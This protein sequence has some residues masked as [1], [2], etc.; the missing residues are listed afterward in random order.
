MT[1]D[2]VPS[3]RSIKPVVTI[4]SIHDNHNDFAYWKSQPYL[5]RLEAL[6]E[7]RAE[8]H[9]WRYGYEPGFQR[10]YSIVKR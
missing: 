8:Y 6:E 3:S 10:V 2:P 9:H 4:V 5:A 1:K 7:I